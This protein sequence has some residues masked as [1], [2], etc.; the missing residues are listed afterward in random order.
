VLSYTATADVDSD[1]LLRHNRDQHGNDDEQVATQGTQVQAT[2]AMPVDTMLSDEE[3][4]AFALEPV[5][6]NEIPG[7]GDLNHILAAAYAGQTQQPAGQVHFQTPPTATPGWG[8]NRLSVNGLTDEPMGAFHTDDWTLYGAL[9]DSL[10]RGWPFVMDN[11]D[12]RFPRVED[13]ETASKPL[14]DLR[15]LWHTHLE[16]DESLPSGYT[17]PLPTET[18]DVDDNYRQALHRRLQ[19]RI[20]AETTL[21][22]AEYLNLCVRAYFKH[23]HPIFPIIH[24]A[25]F[26]PTKTNAVLI[27][28]MCSIGSLLTGHPAAVPRGIL[29]FER[30]NKAT[31]SN[32]EAVMR[33]GPDH[34]FAMTQASLLGQTFGLLS[35]RS[36]HLAIVEAFH[37]TIVAWA[38]RDKVFHQHESPLSSDSVEENWREWAQR[39]ER[40]RLALAVH[41]HDAE[42]ANTLHSEPFLNCAS[43]RPQLPENDDMFFASTAREWS[44]LY[45]KR[46]QVIA[47]PASE[48]SYR[49]MSAD[50]LCERLL[51]I[52]RQSHFAV[53]STLEDILSGVLQARASDSLTEHYT[54]KLHTSLIDFSKQYNPLPVALSPGGLQ[55][56]N[57]ILV[58]L[59]FLNAHADVDLL[60]RCIGRDGADVSHTD[61]GRVQ[62]W[63]RSSSDAPRAAAHALAIKRSLEGFPLVSEPP[64]YVP[65]ALFYSA[66]CLFCYI[67]YRGD[68]TV[69]QGHGIVEFAEL[70]EMNVNVQ[71]LL[72]SLGR[73]TKSKGARDETS[74]IYG[75]VDLLR[76]IGHW[77]ISRRFAAI[78]EALIHAEAG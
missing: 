14:A 46:Q 72:R 56:G 40:R 34:S 48:A 21:P 63:A 53:S 37:G 7:I 41:I 36:G 13:L 65:R 8:P 1:S 3:H 31:L 2:G 23:F 39:E 11:E 64:V 58:H 49:S 25:T 51:S 60:E 35:G 70:R 12:I 6:T 54:Q 78:L 22:S 75:F 18:R 20:Q 57:T 29:L 16:R 33:K 62:E 43:R 27:L 26:R 55:H 76:R 38:R 50:A 24:A 67:K 44:D 28:S 45:R 10:L 74:A 68:A 4:A 17:T 73:E 30:L 19:I 52:P 69:G 15:Q 9:D 47:T 77:E 66:V 59:I 32:F 42:I 61:L 71:A 5:R